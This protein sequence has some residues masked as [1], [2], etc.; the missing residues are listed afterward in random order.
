MTILQSLTQAYDRLAARQEVP[1]FGF[2][3]QNISFCI[4]LNS[5]G[6]LARPPIDLRG[7]AGKKPTAKVL[8]VPYR[9]RTS[10]VSPQFLWDKSSYVLGIS[11]DE[12]KLKNKSERL[13]KDYEAF[14]Q[15]HFTALADY[16]TDEGIAA[17]W[18]FLETWK[19]AEADNW[20]KK[21]YEGILDQNI[22]FALESERLNSF[23]HNRLVARQK[24]AKLAAEKE[25]RKAI[26][27]IT[28]ELA[29]VEKIHP[30]IKGVWGGQ[31]SGAS[32]VSFNCD[33]FT[34]YGYEKGDNAP[35]S[36]A[37]AFAYT[38]VLNKFLEKGSDNR[39]QLAVNTLMQPKNEGEGAAPRP[40][41]NHFQMG[42]TSTVFWADA[43]D[44]NAAILAE[45]VA[46][47]MLAG[48]DTIDE[49]AEAKH[50]IKPILDGIRRGESLDR[51][52][53]TLAK[54]VKFYVLGLAAPSLARISIRF[55]YES[56]FGALTQNYQ[57][58][59]DDMYI[60]TPFKND[61]PVSLSLY[62]LELAVLRKYE[63]IPPRL[64][65]D[66]MRAIL[67]GAD[68]PLTLLSL[69]LTRIR[70]AKKK[71]QADMGALTRR[72][73]LIK[74]V[75]VRNKL[76][77]APV[78]LDESNLDV[79]Y[80]LG[81]LFAVLEK[82]QRAALGENI[83]ASIRDKF[84]GSAS[85]S[86]RNVFPILMRLN[87]HHQSKALKG[88]KRGLAGF[89]IQEIAKITNNLPTDFPSTLN[90]HQQGKFTLG[91]YQQSFTKKSDA[92]A[93]ETVSEGTN[94]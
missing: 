31:S 60:E 73:Q 59:L 43:T 64:G 3:N 66:W 81:R 65:G 45:M 75:L 40:K 94:Q 80:N 83:N 11:G 19:P 27:L 2:S 26:C 7:T 58:F 78:A 21:L 23:L 48:N 92:P 22:V 33:A 46:E 8:E 63:N 28:G 9:D 91:Y 20:P 89:F 70:A 84:Y 44:A 56:S 55:W 52:A 53:P 51:L 47:Q 35:V 13:T 38:T 77:E 87:M 14:R 25:G 36:E 93:T 88:E 67:T 18:L 85:A 32:I 79:A 90:L 24:W 62:L 72:V 68:F 86:P 16:R 15:Y 41:K 37:A 76:W 4:S 74:S 17:L 29:P 54:G 12:K 71:E 42:D 1:S 57:R 34:S 30:K 6:S 69:A 82:L 39:E 50:E 61:K 49:A 5:D 10:G